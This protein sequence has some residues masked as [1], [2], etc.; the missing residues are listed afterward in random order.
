MEMHSGSIVS[1]QGS[2][3]ARKKV[4]Q[5][6]LFT[7]QAGNEFEPCTFCFTNPVHDHSGLCAECLAKY[8]DLSQS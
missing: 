8:S 1:Y 6:V 2:L 5:V 3:G 7:D 4:S